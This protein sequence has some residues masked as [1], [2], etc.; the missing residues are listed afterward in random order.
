MTSPP[1]KTHRLLQIAKEI[2]VRENEVAVLRREFDRLAGED[3]GPAGNDEAR[4]AATQALPRPPLART[5]SLP[6]RIQDVLDLSPNPLTTFDIAVQL[7]DKESIDSIRAALS[8]LIGRRDVE[9][10]AQGVYRSTRAGGHRRAAGGQDD[11]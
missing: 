9:R 1:R 8:K 2:L 4:P 3:G 10:V 7:G 6:Q 11:D 5:S